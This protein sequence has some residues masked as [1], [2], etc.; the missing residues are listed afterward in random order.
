MPPRKKRTLEDIANDTSLTE[1]QKTAQMVALHI[2]GGTLGGAKNFGKAHVLFEVPDK[3]RAGLQPRWVEGSP[4]RM[5]QARLEGYR[6][7][8]E[9]APGVLENRELKELVLMV[10]AESDAEQHRREIGARADA[11]DRKAKR[12][13]EEQDQFGH[14]GVDRNNF[15]GTMREERY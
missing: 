7:P 10:R 8:D 12:L 6:M 1:E 5:G 2:Q 9:V 11:F 15:R 13:A 4:A 14:A 3:Y